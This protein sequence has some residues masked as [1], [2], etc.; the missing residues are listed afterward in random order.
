VVASYLAGGG[1]SAMRGTLT[2]QYKHTVSRW[3]LDA[4]ME[5]KQC[6]GPVLWGPTGNLSG[7]VYKLPTITLAAV[8]GWLSPACSSWHHPCFIVPCFLSIATLSF[9]AMRES[10]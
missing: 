1:A 2:V 4:R 6:D 3:I 5:C 7:H 8:L 9:K 10:L